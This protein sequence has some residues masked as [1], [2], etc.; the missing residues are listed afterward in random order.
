[1]SGD[2]LNI[3]RSKARLLELISVATDEEL[4][5]VT[6]EVKESTDRRSKLTLQR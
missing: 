6:M 5:K 4:T 1:M 3:R 2:I